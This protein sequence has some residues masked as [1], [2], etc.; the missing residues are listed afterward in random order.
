M[1]KI[2]LYDNQKPLGSI[3][4][5]FITRPV[6]KSDEANGMALQTK[7]RAK[8]K[9][10][11]PHS[12]WMTARKW[13]RLQTF[14]KFVRRHGWGEYKHFPFPS[15]MI[16]KNN[17]SLSRCLCQAYKQAKEEEKASTSINQVKICFAGP[18]RLPS[19]P[20]R[21]CLLSVIEKHGRKRS[22][23]NCPFI[24]PIK[25]LCL[26]IPFRFID[27]AIPKLTVRWGRGVGKQP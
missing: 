5:G 1:T 20:E 16:W 18:W 23:G 9:N 8:A 13:A 7:F 21:W 3:C 26:F 25:A 15:V 12:A 2:W 27:S 10:G 19:L 4:L 6:S 14:F 22:V 11:L 17:Y 24:Y